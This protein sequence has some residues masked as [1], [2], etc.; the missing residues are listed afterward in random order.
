MGGSKSFTGLLQAINF[1]NPFESG[2]LKFIMPF[3]CDILYV[4][5]NEYANLKK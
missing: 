4:L 1:K 5:E 2:A 3:V